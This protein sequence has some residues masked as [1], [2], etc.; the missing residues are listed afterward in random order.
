MVELVSRLW[1]LPGSKTYEAEKKS[2]SHE[3]FASL[4]QGMHA[5]QESPKN[6]ASGDELFV[7]ESLGQRSTRKQSN[8]IARVEDDEKIVVLI[9]GHVDVLKD[10]HDRCLRQSRFV[11]MDEEGD[12]PCLGEEKPKVLSV[13]LP[14]V[15]GGNVRDRLAVFIVPN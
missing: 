7:S 15:L 11:E 14:N 5:Q 6:Q 12:P 4:S 2:K 13:E 10:A 1:M 9:L 8:K 3:L